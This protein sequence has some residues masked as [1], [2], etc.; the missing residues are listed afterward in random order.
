[1]IVFTYFGG[2]EAVIWVEVVQLEST[3]PSVAAAAILIHSID[4]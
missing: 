2:M 3:S 4:G 1:M